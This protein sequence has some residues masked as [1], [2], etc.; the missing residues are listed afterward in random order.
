MI[1]YKIQICGDRAVIITFPH[2]DILFSNGMARWFA[3][4][5]AE[6]EFDWVVDTKVLEDSAV[7]VYNPT[8]ITY[9]KL[10]M[11]ITKLIKKGTPSDTKGEKCLVHSIPVCFT[12]RYAP[13]LPRLA[14]VFGISEKDI[15]DKLCGKDFL[16]CCILKEGRLRLSSAVFDSAPDMEERKVSADSLIFEN[17]EIYIAP[18]DMG[19][20]GYVIGSAAFDH[21]SEEKESFCKPGDYIELTSV[22]E[23]K[24]KKLW[25]KKEHITEQRRVQR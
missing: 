23:N 20:K 11:K 5:L 2:S 3:R 17:G 16:V 21:F 10:C 13:D 24:F 25:E 9:R 22:T 4:E 19:T 8:F 7:L 18:V 1:D 12:E 15:T 6:R 14:K